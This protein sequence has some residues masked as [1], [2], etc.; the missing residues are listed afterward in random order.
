[1]P[2]RESAPPR[3]SAP[4][5]EFAPPREPA[6]TP[7]APSSGLLWSEEGTERISLV[8][9]VAPLIPVLKTYTF[10]VPSDLR[11][12]IQLGH[13]VIV[14]LGKSGRRTKGFVV[15]LSERPWDTTLRPVESLVDAESRLAPDLIELGRRIAAH[16]VCPMGLTL[17]AMV[18]ESVRRQRGMTTVRY[19]RALAPHDERQ[20]QPRSEGEGGEGARPA[21][22]KLGAAA[23]EKRER[24]LDVLARAGGESSVR[25]LL[26]AS[27]C[28]ATILKGMARDGLIEI[29]ER[30]QAQA[31]DELSQPRMPDFTLSDEQRAAFD[32]IRERL[33]AAR[34]SVTLLHGVSGSGKTEVYIHAIRHVLAQGRQAMLLVP[35][36]VLT[37][38]LV[39]R[40]AARFDRVAVMHSG[41]TESQRSIAWRRVESGEANVVIGTRSA[42]FAPCG[43][44]GLICVDEEQEDSYKNLQAPR[45]HVRDVAI[46]RAHQLGIPVVLGSATPSLET[47]HNC[48]TRA[49]YARV[50]LHKRV[51]D[52]PMPVVHV[53]DMNTEQQAV[54]GERVFSRLLERK[55]KEALERGEQAIILLNRR[56]YATRLWCPQCRQSVQCPRCN[57]SLVAHEAKGQAVCHHCYGRLTLPRV[58]PTLGCGVPLL[59]MGMGTQKAEEALAAHFPAARVRRV[60]SDTM[61]HRD[62]YVQLVS[63]FEAR[64]VDVLVGTQMIAKG[65]DFPHVSLVGVLAAESIAATADFRNQEKLF[66]LLT[67]VAGRAGRAEAS[68]EVVIQTSLTDLPAL[69]LARNHDY[70]GFAQRELALRRHLGYPPFR[71]LARLVMT[72]EREETCLQ[73][74]EELAAAL[75]GF[76]VKLSRSRQAQGGEPPGDGISDASFFADVLGPAPCTRPRLRDHYRYELLLRAGRAADQQ[77]ILRALRSGT[78]GSGGAKAVMLDVD[79]VAFD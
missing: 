10:S 51:A 26:A 68:G 73:R 39:G 32:A 25:F 23:L 29:T 12:S 13:R 67:Q 61:H 79:P 57:L 21:R 38:Q 78:K 53:V 31:G 54:G 50:A 1:M 34:F 52:R 77:Q 22:R 15:G 49:E 3:K 35:E 19:A 42:V 64:R 17:K 69:R 4:T 40:L 7:A 72:H 47:W 11:A 60:D 59:R 2:T 28:T 20:D 66:T 41:L 6:S 74:A 70:E 30:R 56:G 58:C 45:F 65:L 9:E 16:Y 46:F 18:P 37:T 14:G 71:R 8:A 76:I 24:I 55:L 33:D 63:D 5:R 62:L 36:I 43:R 27:G 48:L 75:R 44:L